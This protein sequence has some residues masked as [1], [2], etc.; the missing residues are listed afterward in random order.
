MA[1]DP[2]HSVVIDVGNLKNIG[3]AIE[4]PS[5]NGDG[6]DIDECINAIIQAMGIGPVALGFEAPMFVPADRP[7]QTVDKARG[8][9]G[10]RSFSASAGAAVLVKSL[11]I[12]PYVLRGLTP[13]R[14]ATRATFNWTEPLQFGD[15]LLFEAFVTNMPGRSH[16]ECASAALA[17]FREGMKFPTIFES[18]IKEPEVFNLLGA[19][20]LREGWR[21]DLDVLRERCLVV[22][23]RADDERYRAER[24]RD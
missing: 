12:A 18:A 16:V 2:L 9:E 4:G 21:T 17:A 10:N 7:R 14:A 24:R 5:I 8:G 13:R 11:V 6:A 1:N 19:M 22:R 20:L 23:C 3:W 15:L